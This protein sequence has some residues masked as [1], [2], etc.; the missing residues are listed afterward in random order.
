MGHFPVMLEACVDA[1]VWRPDGCYVDGT[2]GGG[3]HTEAILHRL[4]AEGSL[5]GFDR[6]EQAI[7]RVQKRLSGDPRLSLVH[8][9]FSNMAARLDDRGVE[10][11]DGLFL[12]LGVSS[13]QLDEADRGFSFQSKGPLDMRMDQSEGLT[14]REWIAQTNEAEM[15]NAIYTFGEERAARRIARAIRERRMERPFETTDDL[16]ALVERIKGRRRGARTH[17]ATLTFQAIRMV[18]NRELESI[19]LVLNEMIKRI[20]VGGRLVVLTFHSLEDR[21]V[22]QFFAG[23]IPREVSLQEGGIRIEGERPF[24]SWLSKKPICADEAELK[25]NPR[26]RSAKL[27]VITVEG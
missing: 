7:A 22:K 17:P 13:F 25:M 1:L 23:H 5:I 18:I 24:V 11:V 20:R 8:S 19:E 4:S 21:I 2:V 26:S 10:E 12:D 16:A 9:N 6:D 14:A 3:G 15:A 27:R